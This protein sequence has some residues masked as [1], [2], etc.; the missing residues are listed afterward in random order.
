MNMQVDHSVLGQI[1]LTSLQQTG[2]R[3]NHTALTIAFLK[4]TDDSGYQVLS[5]LNPPVTWT[6]QHIAK[7]HS[8]SCTVQKEVGLDFFH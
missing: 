6:L 8:V 5:F 7:P 4:T 1:C 3:K 2:A